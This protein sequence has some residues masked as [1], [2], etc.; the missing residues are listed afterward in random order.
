MSEESL[1][2]RSGI[3]SP[4]GPSS[5]TLESGTSGLSVKVSAI[6]AGALSSADPDSGLLRSSFACESNAVGNA[7]SAATISSDVRY[8]FNRLT[9]RLVET[10]CLRSEAQDGNYVHYV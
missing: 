4:A 3:V 9:F 2:S 7:S 6:R 10:D 5:F 1:L 8:A